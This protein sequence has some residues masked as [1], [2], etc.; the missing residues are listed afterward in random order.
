MEKMARASC[1]VEVTEGGVRDTQRDCGME[2]NKTPDDRRTCT[3]LS[4]ANDT[5]E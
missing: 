2:N 3:S 5:I 1:P 4:A